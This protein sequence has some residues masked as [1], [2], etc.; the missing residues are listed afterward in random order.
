MFEY[1]N[2]KFEAKFRYFE[3][4]DYDKGVF[5]LL[6][7]L[8]KAPVP[9][10]EAFLEHLDKI[11][12]CHSKIVNI[13]GE[14]DGKIVAFGT[15]IITN[16]LE[17]KVGKIENIVTCKTV[18]G[19]GLGKIVIEVLKAQGWVEGCSRITLFC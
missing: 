8:T 17:G 12:R 6:N 9:P 4:A 11:S 10:R 3:A 15:V 16:T 18:R 1:W 14:L 19:K 13:V 7:Q 2:N 5:A